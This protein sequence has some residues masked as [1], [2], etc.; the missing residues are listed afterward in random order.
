MLVDEK[1]LR[2]LR[3]SDMIPVNH[4]VKERALTPSAIDKPRKI[5]EATRLMCLMK[6]SMTGRLAASEGGSG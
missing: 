4:L 5:T 6:S 1:T 3:V 2:Q